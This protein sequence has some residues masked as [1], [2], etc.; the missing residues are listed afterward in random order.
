MEGVL[1]ILM[2]PYLLWIGRNIT[3]PFAGVFLGVHHHRRGR[4]GGGRGGVEMLCC[5]TL[6]GFESELCDVSGSPVGG[7]SSYIGRK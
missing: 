1:H 7:V 5:S 6:A 2:H 3:F 4:Q